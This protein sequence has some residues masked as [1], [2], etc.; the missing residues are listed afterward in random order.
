MG[1]PG[2]GRRFDRLA[3]VLTGAFMIGCLTSPASAAQPPSARLVRCGT[4]SCLRISGHRESPAAVVRV[5]GHVVPSEGERRWAVELP[6]DTVRDWSAPHARTI[7]VS[8]HDPHT[9]GTVQISID[10]P[11]GLL[12]GVTTLASL[13]ISAG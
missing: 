4:E 11:I 2:K 13:A 6:I 5:N 1:G 9:Q 3:P 8:L 12:G 7:E 10:L